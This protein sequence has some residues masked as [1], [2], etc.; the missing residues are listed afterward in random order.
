MFVWLSC[1]LQVV[2]LSVDAISDDQLDCALSSSVWISWADW[3]VFRDG[4]H[5]WH[6]GRIAVDGRGGGEDDV[7]D[8]VLLHAAKEGDGST[9]IDT[10]VFEGD[11]GGFA[12]GLKR[13]WSVCASVV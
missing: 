3:A 5:V 6:T 7:G 13:R 12:Y 2:A 1:L 11:F 8:I 9:N 4:N 10:I